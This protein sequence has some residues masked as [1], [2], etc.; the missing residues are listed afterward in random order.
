M[1]KV[2]NY[3]MIAMKIVFSFSLVIHIFRGELVIFTDFSLG[4][5]FLMFTSATHLPVESPEISIKSTF[6]GV[7]PMDFQLETEI[8]LLISLGELMKN[9]LIL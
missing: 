5:S 6:S 9:L 4:K 2:V 8:L 1:P 3:T 7:S